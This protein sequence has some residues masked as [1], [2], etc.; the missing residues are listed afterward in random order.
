MRACQTDCKQADIRSELPKPMWICATCGLKAKPTVHQLRKTYC[1]KKCM[2]VG[3]SA[4]M[5]GINNPNFRNIKPRI[6]TTCK[7]EYSS[8]EKSRKYC[9]MRCAGLS[10]ENLKKV[11][12]ASLLPRS[13]RPK[14]GGLR[15]CKVCSAEFRSNK[16]TSYCDAH[17]SEAIAARGGH[18]KRIGHTSI[19][20]S[21]SCGYCTKNFEYYPSAKRK[22]CSYNCHLKSG[23]A[24]RAGKAST[25]MTFKYGVKK[26]ANHVEIVAAFKKLGADIIDLSAVGRGVPDLVVWC[27]MAWHLVDIKNPKTGYG[28]RGLNARQKEWADEWKGGPVYLVSTL[29]QAADMV[30][31]R[32]ENLKKYPE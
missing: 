30:N 3:Y 10:P 27:R 19:K 26:D 22:F 1:S 11:A 6:C 23:G 20:V 28:R 9:S 4:R 16:K 24:Q 29:E 15:I 2:A 21:A 8:Y 12:L 31:G 7:S 25:A 18:G 14:L 13:P 5:S 32:L 17:K